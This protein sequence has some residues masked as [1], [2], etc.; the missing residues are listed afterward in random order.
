[1][2]ERTEGLRYEKKN[3][4]AGMRDPDGKNGIKAGSHFT[5]MVVPRFDGGGCWQQHLQIVQAIVKSNGWSEGTAALQPFAH[6][7][8]E[9]LNVALLM[10]GEEREKWEGISNGLSEYYNSPGRLAVFR[11]RIES[12]IRRPG[13]DPAT[14]ATELGILAVRGFRDMG[15][16]CR[17]SMVRDRFIAAQRNCGLRR[18]LDGVSSDTPIGDIVD[19]CRVWESHSDREPS[20][21]AGRGRDSLGESDGSQKVGCLW[22]ELQELL[23][24]SGM[25]PVS[26]LGVGSKSAETPRKVGKG[27]SQLAPLEAISSLVT[28]LLRTAQE[29]RWVDEKAPSEGELGPLSAVSPG[30]GAERGHSVKEWVRACF[31]CGRQGHGVNRCSQVDTFSATRVVGGCPKWPISGVTD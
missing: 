12:T 5:N 7:D 25:V 23:M 13:V 20:S 10:P 30:S 8:G 28:R 3:R 26:V 18:H 31:S 2:T 16:R 14:F 9:A 19:S 29:G 27:D 24:C 6:L 11:R 1:M 21:D 4:S 17:D 15:K 22:T